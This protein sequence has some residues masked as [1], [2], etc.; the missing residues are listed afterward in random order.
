MYDMINPYTFH[1]WGNTIDA[2]YHLLKSTDFDKFHLV[3]K[4]YIS[5]AIVSVI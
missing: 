1:T 3:S 2:T 4:C 5:L